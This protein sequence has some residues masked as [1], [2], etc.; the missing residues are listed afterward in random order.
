MVEILFRRRAKAAR[1]SGSWLREP[2]EGCWRDLVA[3]GYTHDRGVAYARVWLAFGDFVAARGDCH[4]EHLSKWVAPFVTQR[5]ATKAR[6]YSC[7]SV[8]HTLIRYLVRRGSIPPLPPPPPKYVHPHG[9]ILSAYAQF[10]KTDRGLSP[11][12]IHK[13]EWCCGTL[14]AH[15]YGTCGPDLATTTPDAILC[16]LTL[17]GR[18]YRRTTM[19]T[20]CGIVRG[21]L[22]WLHRRGVIPHDL[23]SVVVS[24]RVFKH[25]QCPR[26]LTLPQV[27]S[28][29]MVIDRTTPVGRRDYAMILLLATY[30]LRGGEVACLR[31]DDIDWLQQVLHI[32]KRKTGN[33]GRYPLAGPVAQAIIAYL[34]EGRPASLHREVFLSVQAPFAPLSHGFGGQVCKYLRQA[35]ISIPRPGSHTFRYSCAQRLFEQGM[36]LKSIGDYLGHRNPDSTQRYT[37]IAIDQLRAVACNAGEDLL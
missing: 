12:S 7:R 3:R 36:P 8:V 19:A 35:G 20:N 23:S 13:V 29:L 26:Y 33:S 25:E 24:P 22:A 34:R 31:L 27:K 30:G 14:L 28:V 16:F 6:L 5:S 1:L 21:F 18:R 11:R 37:K 9:S 15:V 4:L 17:Q 10:L 32:G 2:I